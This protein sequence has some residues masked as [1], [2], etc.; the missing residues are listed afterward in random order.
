MPE[1][2]DL[3]IHRH[4]EKYL[5]GPAQAALLRGALDGLLR[6]DE[7]AAAGPYLI[8]SLY[9]DTPD[10]RDYT[11]KL[12]GV[13]E[14]Q[15]LRLR[16]YSTEAPTAKLEIKAKAGSYSH[17]LTATVD[18]AQAQALAAGEIPPQ[19]LRGT[20]AARRAALLL[21]TEHRRPA[22]LVDYQRTA[23]LLP[24]E[25]VRITLDEQVRAAKS[26][27]LFDAGVPMVGLHSGGTVI[28]EIKYD[29]YLPG[30]L[31]GVLSAAGGQ[32][33]SISKYAAAR[34]VLW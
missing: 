19:L 9:F 27:A 26:A 33:M 4:E 22:A 5:L 14:R 29:R 11:D 24:V 15:K 31:R 13:A 2:P 6:R 16:L 12:L 20:P 18:R 34:A 1:R 23:W 8:R 21:R 30:Y 10:D 28:L 17:K 32:R 7:H 25:R 3:T